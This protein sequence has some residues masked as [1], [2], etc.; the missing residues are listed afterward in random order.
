MSDLEVRREQIRKRIARAS[1]LPTMPGVVA[2]VIEIVDD[3]STTGRQLGEE[4][5]KDQV[6]CAKILKLVNSGFYGFSKPISTVSHA[7]TML[8]FDVAKSLVLSSS[9]LERMEESLPGLWSHSLA[10]A[11]A[12]TMIAERAQLPDPEELSVIGLL[13]DLGKVVL[14]Q[15]LENDFHR[16]QLRIDKKKMLFYEAEEEVLGFN[17]GALGGWLLEEWTLP[18]QLVEPI[19]DHHDFRPRREHAQRTA[20]VHLADILCR[21]EA[22]GNG[23]DA[24][25]PRLEPEVLGVLDLDLESI[26]A[27]MG[28][29]HRDLAHL[30]SS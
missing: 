17:H 15:S 20:V 1:N 14:C 30:R 16:I 6:L 4:L 11:R 12:C 23:G 2:R 28:D 25:I 22:L 9:V 18:P 27:L 26:S 5:A 21:A 7:V 3:P 29:M 10:C 19:I 8:G 13:H 24:R